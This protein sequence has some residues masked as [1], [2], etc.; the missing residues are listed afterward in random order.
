MPAHLRDERQD[1]RIQLRPRSGDPGDGDAVDEPGRSSAGRLDRRCA[2]GG[3]D[4][5][6]QVDA[7]GVGDPAQVARFGRR[8]VGHDESVDPGSRR[9]LAEAVETECQDRIQVGHE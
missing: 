1:G 6:H 7:G 3:R 4:E 8:E 2:A 5:E 9:G